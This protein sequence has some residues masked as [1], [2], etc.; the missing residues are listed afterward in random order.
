VAHKRGGL[1]SIVSTKE[2]RGQMPNTIIGI[3]KWMKANRPKVEGMLDAIFTGGDLVRTNPQA[4][5]Y[6]AG[7]SGGVYKEYEDDAAYWEKYY[8]GVVEK[9]KQGLDVELGGSKVNNLADNLLL[10]GMVPG[11]SNLFAATYTVFG[12]I[13]K[14]QYP[15]LMPTYYS[16]E[17][18]LDTSYVQNLAKK[19]AP[20]QIQTHVQA[21]KPTSGSGQTR[22]VVSRRAWK[23][24]FA[25]GRATFTGNSPKLLNQMLKDL[26]VAGGT[27]VEVH[28]HTDAQGT[29]QKNQE[30]SEQRAFAVKSWLEKKSPV[31]FPKGRIRVFAHG[32]ANPVAPNSSE[33]GRAQ[34][35]RVEIVLGTV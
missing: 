5:T 30:L 23:I 16:V 8:K 32:Q 24:T 25:S 34:N 13:V 27:V 28:G 22:R 7:I 31:N 9:D 10:F 1:V 21:A 29:P 17:Q 6:A 18:I 14:Q 15:S 33:A 2:Y 20:T 3:D 11:S 12:D 35:R 4:L 19:V 26:L